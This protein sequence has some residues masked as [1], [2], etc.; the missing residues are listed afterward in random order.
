MNHVDNYKEQNY[1]PKLN[2]A[3]S[4]LRDFICDS[5]YIRR[6]SNYRILCPNNMIGLGPQ[7]GG[8]SDSEAREFSDLW[9][10]DAVHPSQAACCKMAEDLVADL[11]NEEARYTNLVRPPKQDALKWQR[12]DDSLHRAAWVS[13]CP[14]ALP[15][16]NSAASGAIHQ[17]RGKPVRGG[18]KSSRGKGQ[19]Y[20]LGWPFG[21][22]PGGWG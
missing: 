10:S 20:S 22:G 2:I 18:Q 16:R 17:S 12:V 9:G 8:I 7:S 19:A 4:G 14:A 3:I 1:L 5:L 11:M 15:R 21:S 6:A 13:G